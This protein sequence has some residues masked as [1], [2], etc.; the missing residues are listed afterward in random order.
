M[1]IE[2]LQKS[3][4]DIY[5][6]IQIR[7][8]ELV[9]KGI[10]NG[11]EIE[12]IGD[13]IFNVCEYIKAD[14][15]ILWILQEPYDSDGGGWHMRERVYNAINDGGFNRD[16]RTWEKV[17]YVSWAILNSSKNSSQFYS[18]L[19]WNQLPDYQDNVNMLKVLEKIA[20]INVKKL[21]NIHGTNRNYAEI[22]AAY[23]ENKEILR[24]QIEAY[25]PHIIIGGSTLNLF[26][27]DLNI[28]DNMLIKPDDRSIYY[29]L[30][31]NAIFI[32]AYHPANRTFWSNEG[33]KKYCDDILFAVET[34]MNR[35][36][37]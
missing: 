25:Q 22:C 36:L 2:E 31:D 29:S 5:D 35:N 3:E 28:S 9:S 20:Y 26:Y 14:Y 37:L 33:R 12:P 10:V 18:L 27:N 16:W 17:L 21:P 15:R 1:T 6:L 11:N 30:K 13:G 34:W 24:M 32:D 23:E 19:R 8:K 7:Y 4:H